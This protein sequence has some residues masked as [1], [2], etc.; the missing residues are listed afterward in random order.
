MNLQELQNSWKNQHSEQSK[1]NNLVIQLFKESRQNKV[2]SKL[3]KLVVYNILF[4]VFNLLVII[5]SFKFIANNF[6]NP[7]V[8]IPAAVLIIL[9]AI[10]FYKNVFQLDDISKIKFDTPIVK[11]QKIIEKLKVKRVK[12]NRF[13]FILSIIYFWLMVVLVFSFDIVTLI[14][15]VWQNAALVVIFHGAF[16]ILWFPLA[17]WFLNKYNSTAGESKLW[18]KFGKNS[19]LTDHSVNSSLNSAQ[20]FLQE[21]KEFEQG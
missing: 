19:Y 7:G 9:S 15:T 10:A 3:K 1:Q 17:F 18:N 21:I 8:I 12:H 13:I 11:L 4:M 5:F 20:L 16:I 6:P 14:S 2:K